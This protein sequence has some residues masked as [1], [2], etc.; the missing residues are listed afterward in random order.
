MAEV[1]IHGVEQAV[2]RLRNLRRDIGTKAVR[3]AA[4]RAMRI[5]RDDARR[6]AST[7][8]DPETASNI[9]KAI[10]TRYDNKASKRE[11]GVVVKV[12]VQG[13]ARPQKGAGDTGHWR[14]K[15]FGTSH[16]PAEPFMRP[17][18]A[19]NAQ[20]VTDKLV[21]ELI[22]QIDKAVAKAKR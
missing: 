3:S 15:E 20:A 6:K 5:V 19:E 13:G 1:K 14:Y 9:A 21:S 8:D 17:A 16:M 4:I 7:F 12:G 10:V 18:L 22:P 2:A 11:G